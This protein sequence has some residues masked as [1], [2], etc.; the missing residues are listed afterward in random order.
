M[1]KKGQKFYL[2]WKRAIDIF[3]SI[4]GITLLSPLL[5]L[6]SIITKI[7]SKGPVFFRQERLG[8]NKK[9][10]RIFKFRSMRTD[11]PEVAPSDISVETQQSMVTKWGKF[12]RKTSLDE[13]PQLFNILFGHMSFI[14]PR[15]GAAHNEENLVVAR[16]SFTPNAFLVKPGLSGYAQVHMKRNHDINEKAKE[17]SYYVEHLSFWLDAKI[18]IYSIFCAFGIVKGK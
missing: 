14:G 11:A 12:M 5:I 2:F 7:T 18:F 15:P 6:C 13:I 8:K 17:D 16:E 4:L 1:L 9:V 10:F 3:G